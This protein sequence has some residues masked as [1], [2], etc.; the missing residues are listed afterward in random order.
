L[1][2]HWVYGEGRA[3]SALLLRVPERNLTLIML[4]N[5]ADPSSAARLHD[6]NVLRSPIAIAFLKYF[7]LPETE[8]GVSIDYAGDISAIKNEALSEEHNPLRFDELIAQAQCRYYMADF[9]HENSDK[10]QRLLR[11]VYELHPQSFDTGDVTL[12]WMLGRLNTPDLQ[13]PT[14]RLVQSFD[15][16]S[17]HRPEVLYSIGS[18]YEMAGDPMNSI[19]YYKLLADRPGFNDEWY[20]IN[21]SLRLGRVYISAGDQESGRTYIWKSA[22]E[23]RGGGFYPAYMKDL[24]QELRQS[25]IVKQ[26]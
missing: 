17:D 14:K 12:M 9:L 2:L 3:D 19:K 23:S 13:E 5:S 1:K 26:R 24:V 20:K 7:V 18:F 10:A 4:A 15:V 22:L 11:L 21:G 25:G 8:R 16:A 6:G